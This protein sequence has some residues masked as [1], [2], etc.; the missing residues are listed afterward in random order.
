MEES[1]CN[2]PAQL[3]NATPTP[4]M[5]MTHNS[6]QFTPNNYVTSNAT[7]IVLMT[8]NS[9]GPVTP[10]VQKQIKGVLNQE[11]APSK[12]QPNQYVN[13]TQDAPDQEYDEEYEDEIE[14]DIPESINDETN[15]RDKIPIVVEKDDKGTDIEF[16]KKQVDDCKR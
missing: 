9:H 2:S 7:P 16:T 6:N 13:V 3:S 15:T 12:D 5:A 11:N 14:E 4:I 8:Q 10:S 1:N